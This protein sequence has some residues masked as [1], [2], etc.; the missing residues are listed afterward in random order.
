[1]ENTFLRRISEIELQNRIK[2][3][4]IWINSNYKKGKRLE[5]LCCKIE[6][7]DFSKYLKIYKNIKIENS[8]IKNSSF[9]SCEF[10]GCSFKN[11]QLIGVAK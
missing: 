3:H 1:M 6:N 4:E 10:I 11:S 9:K 7:V 2:L 8:I 5:L